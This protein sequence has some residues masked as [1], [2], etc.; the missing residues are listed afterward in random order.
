MRLDFRAVKT[1]SGDGS[2]APCGMKAFF[3][4]IDSHTIVALTCASVW[5]KL[6]NV[7]RRM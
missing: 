4:L 3:Q 2:I 7:T 1:L 6:A 5:H